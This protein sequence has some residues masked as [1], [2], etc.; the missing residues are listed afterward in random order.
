LTENIALYPLFP[1]SGK[2]LAQICYG[3]CQDELPGFAYFGT[4]FKW[5]VR[6]AVVGKIGMHIYGAFLGWLFYF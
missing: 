4:E 3:L 2:P 1:L 6:S 5:E